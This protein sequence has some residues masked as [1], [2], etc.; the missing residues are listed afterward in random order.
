M[1]RYIFSSAN[2]NVHHAGVSF[3]LV[4]ILEAKAVPEGTTAEQQQ[5]SHL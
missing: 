5:T 3:T 4:Y 1:T 2:F